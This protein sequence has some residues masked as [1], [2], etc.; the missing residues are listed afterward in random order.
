[1]ASLPNIN[2]LGQLNELR[3]KGCKKLSEIPSLESSQFA[4]LE[5]DHCEKVKKLPQ[6]KNL[7]AIKY[8]FLH[9][10]GIKGKQEFQKHL[11]AVN[12]KAK[13]EIK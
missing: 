9:R 4:R 3:L 10:T 12:P 11:Q 8:I 5:I 13:V 2:A 1:M 7:A 6:F